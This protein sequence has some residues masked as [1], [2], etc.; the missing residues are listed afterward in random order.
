MK[1]QDSF[2]P[3]YNTRIV[4]FDN[5]SSKQLS[6]FSLRHLYDSTLGTGPLS[7]PGFARG[8]G[9]QNSSA[10]GRQRRTRYAPHPSV[11]TLYGTVS[12]MHIILNMICN[13]INVCVGC[14]MHGM[15]LFDPL[16]LEL[17]C[18]ISL[19]QSTKQL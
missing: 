3:W 13:V 15:T 4:G 16:L 2:L 11:V 12:V 5:C 6:L 7:H 9:M 18:S 19:R 14:T 8:V 10:Q 17:V 1:I